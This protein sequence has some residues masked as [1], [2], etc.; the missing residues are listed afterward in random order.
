MV[1]AIRRRPDAS[2][3]ADTENGEFCRQARHS[4]SFFPPTVTSR[5]ELP[6][7]YGHWNF[8]EALPSVDGDRVAAWTTT[9]PLNNTDERNRFPQPR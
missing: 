8:I 9:G 7:Q 2:S 4:A 6:W 1:S 3:M 5:K